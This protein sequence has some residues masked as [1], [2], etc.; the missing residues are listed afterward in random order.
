MS[1]SWHNSNDGLDSARRLVESLPDPAVTSRY[2]ALPHSY[3]CER[4]AEADAEIGINLRE[5]QT[6][7]ERVRSVGASL[8]ARDLRIEEL[9]RELEKPALRLS[10]PEWAQ[11]AA[12]AVAGASGIYL[13]VQGWA[14]L[15]VWIAR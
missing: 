9:E 2:L 10:V 1:C 7:R 5:I 8:I 3:V 13:L 4:L 12:L 14:R 11:I 15:C 6:L